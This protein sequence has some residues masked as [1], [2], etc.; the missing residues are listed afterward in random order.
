MMKR[1]DMMSRPKLEPEST[2][3]VE[4]SGRIHTVFIMKNWKMRYPE[5]GL[6][7]HRQ[8]GALDCR[9]MLDVY[10][11]VFE[12]KIV[13]TRHF[14]GFFLTFNTWIFSRCLFKSEC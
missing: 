12:D 8:S 13:M 9:L 4:Y 6:E 14:P 3:G 11:V 2:C 5:R 7:T 1:S 10:L